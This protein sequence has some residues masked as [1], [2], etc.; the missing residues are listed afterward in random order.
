MS[1]PS[2]RGELAGTGTSGD[3]LAGKGFAL[4][5][6]RLLAGWGARRCLSPGAT[7]AHSDTT[8][9]KIRVSVVMRSITSSPEIS[10]PKFV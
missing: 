6:R 10:R 1:Q 4:K 2:T 5:G 9:R 3:L 8:T 7:P